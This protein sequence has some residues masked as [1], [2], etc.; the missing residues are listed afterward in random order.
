MPDGRFLV[1]ER[2]GNLRIV[3]ADGSVPADT[4]FANRDGDELNQ[5]PAGVNYGW[6]VISY[7]IDYSGPKMGDGIQQ[8]EGMQQPV[9]YWDPVIA[10][11][12]LM[13]YRG[14]LFPAWK[15]SIFVGGLGG[16]KLVRLQM[17][18]DKVAGEEWLLADR[19][20]RI[21]DVQQGPD[22]SIYVSTE[23][24]GDSKILRLRPAGR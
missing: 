8:Q 18:G 9:Y 15:G 10:P 24:G 7:G 12:G 23:E 11:S 4:P 21:R 22:G 2:P 5:P 1:T 3:S 14:D 17:D 13:V 20:A 16:M 19:R 6:P